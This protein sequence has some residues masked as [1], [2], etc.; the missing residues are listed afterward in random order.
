MI[1][2]SLTFLIFLT[3]VVFIFWQLKPKYKSLL[4][5]ISSCIFYG[6]WRW[7]FIPLI[8]ISAISDY[9]ISRNINKVK[10]RYKKKGLLYLSLF[11][12]L[13]LLFYFK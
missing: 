5:V 6:F 1:F 10:E 12:N 4:L 7:D 11:I 13:G 9:Y 2:N 8:F 3:I